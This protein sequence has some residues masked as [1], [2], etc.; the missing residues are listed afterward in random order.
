MDAVC[1]NLSAG[2]VSRQ[3]CNH[4]LEN[5]RASLCVTSVS[6]GHARRK[7]RALPFENCNR[8]TAFNLIPQ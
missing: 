6:W 3:V 5:L 1:R 8:S 7:G 4:L 2:P